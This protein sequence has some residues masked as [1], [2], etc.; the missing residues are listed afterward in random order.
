MEMVKIGGHFTQ[1]NCA[2]NFGGHGFWQFSPELMFRTFSPNNG[3]EIEAVLMH[4]VVSGGAWYIVSDP[5]QVRSRVELCNSRPTYILTVAR[6][7]SRALI[8][9]RTPQQ[10]DYVRLWDRG[11]DADDAAQRNSSATKTH[12]W[13]KYVPETLKRVVRS[14]RRHRAA[15]RKSAI[16]GFGRIG[17]R[18][19]YRRMTCYTAK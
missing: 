3:Y 14:T 15:R 5:D 1:V 6:R 13:R 17:Y 10:S 8:F 11:Q 7:V 9:E 18:W 16:Q 2:N 19:G 4:E 12:N